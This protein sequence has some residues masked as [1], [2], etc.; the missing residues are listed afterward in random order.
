MF[1]R[2]AQVRL[3]DLHF[4]LDRRS[5]LRAIIAIHDISRGPA[6]GGCRALH[7]QD[8]QDAIEDA[9]RL[10]QGM[11]Y[12]AALAGLDQGGGKA[13]ILLPPEPFDRQAL[14]EAFGRFVEELGGRY[15]TAMDSG[16]SIQDMD[17][18]A[19]QT[20]HVTCTSRQGN[21]GP[22]TAL[23][24]FSG[25]QAGL[26][27]LGI[28][29]LAGR[30]VAIQGLGNVG[31]ALADLLADAGAHLTV[32]DHNTDKIAQLQQRHRNIEVVAPEALL[33][34]QCDVL[35]PCALGGILNNDSLEHLHCRLIAG[36]ANNQLASA[37]TGRQL[38]LKGVLYL[39]D[40]LLN[41]GGLI[42]V[43]L[44]HRKASNAEIEQRIRAIGTQ[45][46][47]LL[48]QAQARR[49]PPSDLADLMA[50]EILYGPDVID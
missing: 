28:D 43:A 45:I 6:L 30:H 9:L 34:V 13:V 35:A 38:H 17:W 7:Y 3:N 19:G 23:G 39:P 40:F 50:E 41:A 33:S 20:E 32:T 21:P 4:K 16:T 27:H 42:S 1:K 15:I 22:Y 2:L 29:Q 37:E 11:S 25:I 36:S 10:A 8:E 31:E 44:Q 18:I 12:K 26:K 49:Q 47:A 5:G 48:K 14:F 24:V 46:E